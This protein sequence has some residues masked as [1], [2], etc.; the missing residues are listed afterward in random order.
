MGKCAVTSQTMVVQEVGLVLFWLQR[1]MLHL[2]DPVFCFV[3]FFL[4][5]PEALKMELEMI[6]ADNR[7]RSFILTEIFKEQSREL[8]SFNSIMS[9]SCSFTHQ[10]A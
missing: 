2:K 5:C 7:S 6:S 9:S 3:C 4:H 1:K 10:K 8:I